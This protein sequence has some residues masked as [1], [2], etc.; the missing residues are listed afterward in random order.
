MNQPEYEREYQF[1]EVQTFNECDFVTLLFNELRKNGVLKFSRSDLEKKLR[2][3]SEDPKY[4][5][6]FQD[7]MLGDNHVNL[8]EG[9]GMMLI[10]KNMY[11]IA[12]NFDTTYIVWSKESVALAEADFQKTPEAIEK[13]FLMSELV[14]DYLGIKRDEKIEEAPPK[15]FRRRK[16]GLG[17]P[18]TAWR[19]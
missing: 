9:F 1:E 13:S 19:A 14:Q 4:K 16:M 7:L 15:Y 2:Y 6:L 12:P 3:Y 11:T 10:A 8:S 17:L 5:L 18:P